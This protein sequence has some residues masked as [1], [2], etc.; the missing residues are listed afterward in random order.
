[1]REKPK[2]E[3]EKKR[4]KREPDEECDAAE[5][6]R[7]DRVRTAV[8][9]FAQRARALPGPNGPLPE[10]HSQNVSEHHRDAEQEDADEQYRHGRVIFGA[11]CGV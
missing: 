9:N 1:M 3:D 2:R 10:P 5:T 6:R 7:G 11:N 8:R 4:R